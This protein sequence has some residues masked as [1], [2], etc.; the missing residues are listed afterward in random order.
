MAAYMADLPTEIIA[1]LLA[2]IDDHASLGNVAAVCHTFSV[3]ASEV[4]LTIHRPR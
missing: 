2:A 4:N 3:G 1:I